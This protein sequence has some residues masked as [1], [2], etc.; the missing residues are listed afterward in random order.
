MDLNL[1]TTI[2]NTIL[3]QINCEVNYSE[4]NIFQNGLLLNS[5][6]SEKIHAVSVVSK[7]KTAEGIKFEAWVE[8][9]DANHY[10]VLKYKIFK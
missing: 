7:M 6:I 1:S 3:R 10:P 9:K 4:Q 5:S 8:R 2:A